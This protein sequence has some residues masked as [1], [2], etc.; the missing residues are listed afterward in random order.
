M[1]LFIEFAD[2]WY[3]QHD[4]WVIDALTKLNATS[5]LGAKLL[6]ELQRDYASFSAVR[7]IRTLGELGD[8]RAIASLIALSGRVSPEVVQAIDQALMQLGPQGRA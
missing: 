7:N 2:R 8:K 4:A 1:D 5:V 6:D 3:P